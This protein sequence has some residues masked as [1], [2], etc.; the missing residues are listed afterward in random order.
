MSKSREQVQAFLQ[1]IDITGKIVLDIGVQDKPAKSWTKGEPKQY[2]TMDVDP[3][4]NPD[5]VHDFNKPVEGYGKFDVV[6]CLETMEHLWNPVQA[7]QNIY[8][9]LKEGGIAYI[10]SPFINPIHDT[11]DMLRYTDEW[12]EY[13]GSLIGF[14]RVK[15]TPRV[16][17]R[18]EHDLLQFYAQEGLRMSKIRIQNGEGHKINHIGYIVELIK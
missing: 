8:E 4:W 12:Y 1:S 10:T 5:Y 14:T 9:L 11:H 6:F 16:A 13:V 17:T 7:L 15:A 2:Y 3:Q 18:G